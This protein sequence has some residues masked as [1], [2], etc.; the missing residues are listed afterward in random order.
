MHAVPLAA[1]HGIDDELRALRIAFA[2]RNV[3]GRSGGE[4]AA[5]PNE[6]T[7]ALQA[8]SPSAVRSSM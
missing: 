8:V 7:C 5:S 4:A 3:F 6:V 1:V 2:S